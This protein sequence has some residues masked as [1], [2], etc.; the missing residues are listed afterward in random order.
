MLIDARS[1]S[2]YAHAHIPGA[3]SL[4]L[5]NDEERARVGTLY[6]QVSRAAAVEEGLAIFAPKC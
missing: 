1:P 5:L 2:E 6:K 4:P 3:C